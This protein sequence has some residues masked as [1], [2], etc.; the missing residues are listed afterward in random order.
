MNA[1]WMESGNASQM[2]RHAAVVPADTE[3]GH[4]CRLLGRRRMVYQRMLLLLLLC[5]LL[6]LVV[7]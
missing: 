2:V 3:A 4:R 6:L 1:F 5:L 7:V